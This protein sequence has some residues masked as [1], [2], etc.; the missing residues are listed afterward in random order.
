MSFYVLSCS[1]TCAAG[2]RASYLDPLCMLGQRLGSVIYPLLAVLSSRPGE[3][4]AEYNSACVRVQ[5]YFGPAESICAYV[6]ESR[7]RMT[8]TLQQP[9]P[10]LAQLQYSMNELLAVMKSALNAT[11]CDTSIGEHG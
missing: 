10:T 9:Q 4:N 1:N 6:L 5:L 11:H 7:I 2:E 3:C 8:P